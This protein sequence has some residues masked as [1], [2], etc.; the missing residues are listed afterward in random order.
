MSVF[1]WARYPCTAAIPTQPSTALSLS[2]P[3]HSAFPPPPSVSPQ[4][5]SLR[6]AVRSASDLMGKE[7]TFKNSLAMKFT[8]QSVFL[9]VMSKQCGKL[10][11]QE[12]LN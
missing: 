5:L 11:C 8:T 1:S 10:D 6:V 7:F 3:P 4:E 2:C 12:V 9:L